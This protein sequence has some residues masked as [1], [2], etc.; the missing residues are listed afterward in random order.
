MDDKAR[1]PE[2]LRDAF[3]GARPLGSPQLL[4]QRRDPITGDLELTLLAQTLDLRQLVLGG[5]RRSARGLRLGCTGEVQL[6]RSRVAAKGQH[7]NPKR[8]PCRHLQLKPGGRAP[9]RVLV[10]Q[11]L[12]TP[13]ELDAQRRV[14]LL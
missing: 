14:D 10:F 8:L 6:G 11:D 5:T 1:P 12:L 4:D 7:T 13:R 3:T 9:A 2:R